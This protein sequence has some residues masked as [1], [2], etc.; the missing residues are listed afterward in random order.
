MPPFKPGLQI[1]LCIFTILGTLLRPF[2]LIDEWFS[3]HKTQR[4]PKQR[5]T[6]PI[7]EPLSKGHSNYERLRKEEA[8]Y[9]QRQP[10]E[11]SLTLPLPP[12]SPSFQVKQ[13]TCNQS[14]S[15]L[16]S[17]MSTELRLLI[18]EFAIAD[19][20]VHIVQQRKRL[21]NTVCTESP[22]S[23]DG[24]HRCLG[25]VS[26]Y[27]DIWLQQPGAKLLSLLKTCRLVYSEAI[28]ILYSRN[29]F[30]LEHLDT[31][32][33]F[34][35]I[36]LPSRFNSIRSLHL[37]WYFYNDIFADA[38]FTYPPRDLATWQKTCDILAR[39]EGLRVLTITLG[40]RRWE[41]ASRVKLLQSMMK[42][43]ATKRFEVTVPWAWP[44]LDEVAG[45]RLEGMPF[46]IT[47]MSELP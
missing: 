9:F 30:R 13:R 20:V 45:E 34:S 23:V 40:A 37:Y 10:R 24:F 3:K 7:P 43:R 39:M 11:R 47:H 8:A 12:S 6:C 4:R 19:E 27:G 1:A 16:L 31:L 21:C 42:I 35:T 41:E 25:Y 38:W 15:A 17:K 46:S 32:S 22:D 29:T 18:W 36:T 2:D 28:D 44:G 14:Q 5:N 26:G 33:H